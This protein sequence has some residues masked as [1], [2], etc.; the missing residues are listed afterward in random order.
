[1]GIFKVIFIL[2]LS[3]MIMVTADASLHES[4]VNVNPVVLR[5]PWFI[6]T[7]FDAYFG[8]L[9]FYLWVWYRSPDLRSR[10]IW[11]VLIMALGNMAMA[12]YML[13]RLFKLAPDAN[14]TDLLLRPSPAKLKLL[15][16]KGGLQN[17]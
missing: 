11:F 8:F 17:G 7:M 10:L 16:S 14:V 9:T 2:I 3:T 13:I 4:L 12:A 5:D 1:M 15:D 6:A